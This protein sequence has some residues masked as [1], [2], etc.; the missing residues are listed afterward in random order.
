MPDPSIDDR[1]EKIVREAFDLIQSQATSLG[2]DDLGNEF[3]SA[4]ITVPSVDLVV[5]TGNYELQTYPAQ[6]GMNMFEV[7]NNQN[8]QIKTLNDKVIVLEA[9]ATMIQ[10]QQD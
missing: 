5:S 1:Y 3:V 9:L 2:I 6:G 7:I 10:H 8:E 4:N